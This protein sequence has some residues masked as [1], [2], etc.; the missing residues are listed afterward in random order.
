MT[1]ALPKSNTNYVSHHRVLL[2]MLGFMVITSFAPQAAKV[3][4]NTTGITIAKTATKDLEPEFLKGVEEMANRLEANPNHLLAVMSFE[5]GGSFSPSKRNLLGSGATGLIQFMPETAASLGTDTDT[6]AKMSRTEQLA[7]VEKYLQPYKGKLKTL[8][9]TY[10]AVLYPIAV[11]K[12]DNF[13]LF[14]QGSVAYRQN[15]GLDLNRD[16]AVTA[17]EAASKVQ[18]HIAG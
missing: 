11:G 1:I 2:I 6:L 9:D 5:T 8:T 10:M 15:S 14:S 7:Y 12:G 17:G 18:K 16:G 3:V 4:E 13:T